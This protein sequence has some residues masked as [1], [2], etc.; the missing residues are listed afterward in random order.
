MGFTVECLWLLPY[1]GESTLQGK[2]C[3]GS[4]IFG[5]LYVFIFKCRIQ[6]MNLIGLQ[7]WHGLWDFT[8][9]IISETCRTLFMMQ[10]R[11]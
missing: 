5:G 2:I 11:F 4:I 1:G 7:G 8:P 6:I 9:R 3:I 10:S